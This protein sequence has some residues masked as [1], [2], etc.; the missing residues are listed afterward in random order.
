MCVVGQGWRVTSVLIGQ[1]WGRP[2]RPRAGRRV[3]PCTLEGDVYRKRSHISAESPGSATALIMLW[4]LAIHQHGIRPSSRMTS[5]QGAVLHTVHFWY[6]G[7]GFICIGSKV[8]GLRKKLR[9]A[10]YS[11]FDSCWMVIWECLNCFSIFCLN[12]WR[13]LGPLGIGFYFVILGP[14]YVL[15]YQTRSSC[16]KW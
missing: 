4:P 16:Y 1:T 5:N 15:G 8:L 13:V 3:G 9:K 14:F 7:F 11:S 10:S 12:V 6:L 2:M